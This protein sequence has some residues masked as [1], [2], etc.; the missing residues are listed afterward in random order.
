MRV[1]G[2]PKKPQ[3]LAHGNGGGGEE[4]PCSPVLLSDIETSGRWSR[5]NGARVLK[6]S[7]CWWMLLFASEAVAMGDCDEN[8]DDG[9]ERG[10]SK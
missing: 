6:K 7:G 5:E 4:V 8:S 3:P 1:D 2:E 10:M 9:E